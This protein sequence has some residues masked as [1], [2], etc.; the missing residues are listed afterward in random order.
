MSNIERISELANAIGQCIS[1]EI[2][3]QQKRLY[4][5]SHSLSGM[6][7]VIENTM[8]TQQQRTSIQESKSLVDQALKK[9]ES[10]WKLRPLDA[11]PQ[12][13][14]QADNESATITLAA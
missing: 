6:I 14:D 8:M 2:I 5:A 4:E 9:I 10:A 13:T 12:I 11:P 3:A 7:D 1:D